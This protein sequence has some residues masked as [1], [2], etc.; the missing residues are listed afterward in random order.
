MT[1]A[2]L[3]LR[4]VEKTYG[5][6][7]ATVRAVDGV[8]LT[9]NPGEVAV[10][11]G[12]SG[13]GKTTVLSLSGAL[14]RPTSGRVSIMGTDI[15]R[16]SERDLPEIRLRSIGFVFQAFNLLSALT[17]LENVEVA[18]NLAG[19]GGKEAKRRATE[20][21]TELGLGERLHHYPDELSGGEKQRV[22]LARA[23][24]NEP[25]LILADEPTGN[26]DSKSGHMVAELLKKVATE[27]GKSV[28]IVSHDM[29]I[30]DIAD[31][32][33]W[34]E[35]GRLRQETQLVTDPVCGMKIQEADAF[36]TANYEG[37]RYFFCSRT[38]LEKFEADPGRYAGR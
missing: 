33:Y 5:S 29:R 37:R 3:E 27:R 34:L 18:L 14:L 10:I 38:C 12:P 24:A 15:T 19:V 30:I 8:S 2:A 17:A 20:L 25:D 35:D 36:G 32:V 11:M 16:L 9:V 26:L 21:L 23:L 1:T 6:G 7:R 28:L 4:E 13:S 22:A 31:Q